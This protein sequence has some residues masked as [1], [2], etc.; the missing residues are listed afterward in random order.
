MRGQRLPNNG[1][2]VA[3]DSMGYARYVGRGDIFARLRSCQDAQV[4]ELKY[5]SFY[6]VPKKNHEREIET[7][8]I[9]A[10]GPSYNSTN[11]RRRS[12]PFRET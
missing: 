8:L 12:Q 9:R 7:V 5:F 10:A 2:Y 6:V 4:L 1:V 11:G 3:H